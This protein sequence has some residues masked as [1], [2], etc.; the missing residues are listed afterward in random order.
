MVFSIST[1]ELYRRIEQGEPIFLL[2]VR[3]TDEYSNWKI[4]GPNV[5]SINVPYFDFMEDEDKAV[6]QVPKDK[7][8]V[9]ICAHQGSSAY[10][11]DVLD[12]RGYRAVYVQGGMAAW[13]NT[14]HV[15]P[16]V[17]EADWTLLQINRVGKGCLSYFMFSKGEAVVVE[18][19]RNVNLYTELAEKYGVTIRHILDSHM[20]ADHISTGPELAAR[21]GAT[22]YLNSSEGSKVRF[23]PLE[24]YEKLQSGNIEVEVLVVKTPGH[25]PGSLSFFVNRKYLLSGDTIFVGGLGRPDLGGKAREWAED[26]Y[27]TVFGKV[28]ALADDVIVLP[29]HYASFAELN[30]K[31]VVAD[32]LGNIRSRN[33]MMHVT[34]RQRFI[35]MVVESDSALKPPNYLDVLAINR[36]DFQVDAARADELEMGPNRCAAHHAAAS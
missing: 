1:D 23:E 18:P 35:E 32:T 25:T 12:R 15:V 28:A 34:D 8:L 31:G 10:V 16:V 17:E 14:Y 19:L 22:Y 24:K 5:Q 26:L 21:T 3:N 27:D 29:S 13:G 7:D 9:V 4:E 36:G 6:S 2:D 11:A 33:E 30:D 20:H